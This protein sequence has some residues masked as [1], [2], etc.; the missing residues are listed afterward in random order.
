MQSNEM[1]A[2]GHEV[3]TRTDGGALVAARERNRNGKNASAAWLLG[4][5]GIGSVV[6]TLFLRHSARTRGMKSTR[7][8]LAGAA[9]AGATVLDAIVLLRKRKGL[10]KSRAIAV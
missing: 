2:I 8:K 3:P 7:L 6:A 4:A 10:A 9:T 5:L 1:S